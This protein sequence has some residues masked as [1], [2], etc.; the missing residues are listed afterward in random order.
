[1]SESRA[2]TVYR[3][4]LNALPSDFRMRNDQEMQAVF[5]EALHRARGV[6]RLEVVRTWVV[7]VADLVR[8]AVEMAKEMTEAGVL[9][10][11]LT[12]T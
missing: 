5:A 12:S 4:L 1:M 2:L 9:A 8:S 6:S 11:I 10:A 3:R 7:A